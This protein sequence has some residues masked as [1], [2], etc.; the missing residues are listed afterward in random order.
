MDTRKRWLLGLLAAGAGVAA[1]RI[2]T[3]RMSEPDLAASLVEAGGEPDTTPRSRDGDEADRGSTEAVRLDLSVARRTGLEPV[4][5]F[6]TFLQ[7]TRGDSSHLLFVRYDD[8][9]DLADA[10]GVS[11]AEFLTRLD[12]LGVV[13]SRN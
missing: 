6:L 10:E 13:V 11:A 12:Q 5:E 8:L 9:D 1:W 2:W 4:V 7:Q 3:M